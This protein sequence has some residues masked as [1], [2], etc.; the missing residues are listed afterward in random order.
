MRQMLISPFLSY[1]FVVPYVPYVYYTARHYHY[2]SG[3][4]ALQS[5]TFLKN[6]LSCL[7]C[8]LSAMQVRT[9]FISPLNLAPNMHN[10]C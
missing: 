1:L 10:M 7:L 2:R 5:P 9:S 4:W 8:K 6:P 3:C